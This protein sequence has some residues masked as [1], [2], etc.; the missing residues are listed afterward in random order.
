MKITARQGDLLT[1]QEVGAQEFQ[2]SILTLE[3]RVTDNGL[4]LRAATLASGT[5]TMR[6]S[7]KP[8]LNFGSAS[9]NAKNAESNFQIDQGEAVRIAQGVI[10][11]DKQADLLHLRWQPKTP[12]WAKARALETTIRQVAGG[13][14]LETK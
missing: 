14:T 6:I 9:P 8:E 7:F 1:I 2:T 12:D 5:H 10:T 13:Y 11:L 4:A 3:A